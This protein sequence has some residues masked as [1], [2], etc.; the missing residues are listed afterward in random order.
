MRPYFGL[1]F[2]HTRRSLLELLRI[3]LLHILLLF[4]IKSAIFECQSGIFFRAEA[5][6][7][8]FGHRGN[9]RSLSA[10]KDLRLLL[11]LQFL[12]FRGGAFICLLGVRDRVHLLTRSDEFWANVD[13]AVK[14]R[15]P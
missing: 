12:Q 3:L 1:F 13:I 10:L 11:L 5:Q 4:S 6:C 14:D 7:E 8:S 15:I 9:E 2:G